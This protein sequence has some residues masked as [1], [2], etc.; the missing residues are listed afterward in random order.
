MGMRLPESHFEIL[1]TEA[2]LLGQR[3]G[4]LLELLLKRRLGKIQISRPSEAPEKYAFPEEK[5]HATRLWAWYM[6][7]EVKEM[8]D[9][10]RLRLGRL[11]PLDWTVMALNEWIGGPAEILPAR[12]KGK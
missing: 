6:V 10:D 11:D 9:F 5:F 7:P 8:L 3:K 12:R 2:K 4:Q 1:Q